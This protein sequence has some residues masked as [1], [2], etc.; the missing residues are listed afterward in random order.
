VIRAHHAVW[1]RDVGFPPLTC[2]RS[3]AVLSIRAERNAVLATHGYTSS[4]HLAGRYEASG[5]AK[6]H[7]PGDVGSWDTLIGPERAIDT[8]KLFVA[9]QH[10]RL[11]LRLYES[12]YDQSDDG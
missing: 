7:K 9:F 10:A 12:R 4:H 3:N 2:R 1:I 5:V 11:I 6:G 8:D